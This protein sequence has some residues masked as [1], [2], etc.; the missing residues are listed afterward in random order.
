VQVRLLV[1]HEHQLLADTLAVALE[2]DP[3]IHVVGI[4]TD[5]THAV[6][7]AR[8][9]WP[10]VILAPFGSEWIQVT[11]TLS[12]E[13]RGINILMLVPSL[14]HDILLACAQAGVVGYLTPDQPLTDLLD[15]IQRVNSGEVL[16]DPRLMRDLLLRS[17]RVQQEA[18]SRDLLQPLAPRELEV[19]QTLATGVRL[20]EAGER[21]GISVHTVRS[22][23]RKIMD[24]LDAR[25]RLEAVVIAVNAGLIALPRELSARNPDE[26]PSAVG[27][28]A[29][30]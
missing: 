25:T 24:K 27:V 4:E 10:D 18:S 1:L 9:L 29:R 5:P 13:L 2:A 20:E 26:D 11:T 3:R 28:R 23:V 30:S 17:A 22:H 6:D 14:N 12:V 19:L 8:T 15:A 21:L 7:H 16:F